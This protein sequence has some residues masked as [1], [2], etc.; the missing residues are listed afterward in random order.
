MENEKNKKSTGNGRE[1]Y[2]SCIEPTIEPTLGDDPELVK[3]DMEKLDALD[4]IVDKVNALNDL[5]EDIAEV[6]GSPDKVV[7]VFKRGESN[8][9]ND[10]RN[11]NT[12]ITNKDDEEPIEKVDNDTTHQIRKKQ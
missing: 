4:N 2:L 11:K 9:M 12:K 6:I 1:R 5:N 8:E 7:E 3:W 10:E